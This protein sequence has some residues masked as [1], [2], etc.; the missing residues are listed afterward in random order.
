M[1][2]GGH[3]RN[4]TMCMNEVLKHKFGLLGKLAFDKQEMI[5]MKVLLDNVGEMSHEELVE[6][7]ECK[8]KY[9][10]EDGK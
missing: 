5:R 6:V 9:T 4:T 2:P 1:Y 8:I 10:G 3:A 7:Y